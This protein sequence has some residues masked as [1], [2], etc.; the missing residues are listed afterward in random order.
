MQQR[1][2]VQGKF[3]SAR[4]KLNIGAKYAI[5]NNYIFNDT[6]GIPNQTSKELIVLSVYFDK[7]FNYQN[8]H[9]RTRLLWQKGSN[10]DF[11]HLP[12]FSAYVSAYYQLLI[13]KVLYT[14]IGVDTRYNT[15][16]YAD[17]YA[18]NT[19]LFY[20]QNEKK[21]GNYPYIDIYAN[22][23]LKRTTVFFKMMNIGSEFINREYITTP[24]Y[25]MNKATFRLGITWAFYD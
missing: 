17:A 20:L 19:G 6:L 4:R 21:Y 22:L 16:Y 18:P 7:D 11:I 10:E 3:V 15:S 13:S 5:L 25:P 1:M 12:D 8:L 14:Q 23:R 2:I 9:F 24:S